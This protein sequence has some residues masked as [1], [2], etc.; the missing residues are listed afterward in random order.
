MFSKTGARLQHLQ[1]RSWVT[2]YSD[3]QNKKR[4]TLAH[5][6]EHSC[7]ITAMQHRCK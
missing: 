7:L 1:D 2:Q 6:V 4:Q 5:S 3:S